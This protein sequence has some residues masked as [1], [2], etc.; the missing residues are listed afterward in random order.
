VDLALVN[1]SVG[2]DTVDGLD[3]RAEEVLAE[4]FETSTGDGG[5]EVNA[6]EQRV[7]LDRSLGR[8]RKGTLGTLASSA[9]TSQGTVVAAQVL[10]VSV[11]HCPKKEKGVKMEK[12]E[13]KIP[14]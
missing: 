9:K 2:K 4:L 13:D 6:L 12:E 14:F 3:G 7:N 11:S 1:L 5:V 10:Y 8:G